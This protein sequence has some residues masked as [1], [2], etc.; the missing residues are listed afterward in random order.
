MGSS[1]QQM[2][3]GRKP[4]SE[5]IGSHPRNAGAIG[6]QTQLLLFEAIFHVSRGKG[7]PTIPGGRGVVRSKSF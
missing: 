3:K 1:H 4:Q 5:L 6:K 7:D 2:G